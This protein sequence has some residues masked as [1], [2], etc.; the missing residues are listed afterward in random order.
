MNSADLTV[1]KPLQLQLSNAKLSILFRQTPASLS[2]VDLRPPHHANVLWRLTQLQLVGSL[3]LEILK[4]PGQKNVN[5]YLRA[6]FS[7][8]SICKNVDVRPDENVELFALHLHVIFFL[9]QLVLECVVE[10]CQV[11]VGLILQLS[12]QKQQRAKTFRKPERIKTNA[13][14]FVTKLLSFPSD[15]ENTLDKTQLKTQ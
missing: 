6:L 13:F 15:H 10:L 11:I 12:L 3:Q 8:G 2:E 4:A 14:S 9:V 1:H 5:F 7:G